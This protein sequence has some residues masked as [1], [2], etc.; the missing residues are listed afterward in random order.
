MP[1]GLLSTFK[2]FLCLLMDAI[3]EL[4]FLACALSAEGW[5]LMQ[6]RGNLPAILL[7]T[8]FRGPRGNLYRSGVWMIT[9]D[10][11]HF[12]IVNLAIP[13]SEEGRRFDEWKKIWYNIPHYIPKYM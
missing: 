12:R 3:W 1:P 5:P 2:A 6:G 10:L 13:V 9:T 7:R 4:N 11:D 8:L